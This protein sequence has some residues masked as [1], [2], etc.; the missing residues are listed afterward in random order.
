[1]LPSPVGVAENNSRMC[2]SIC[3]ALV[4]RQSSMAA[5][6]REVL[7]M[8]IAAAVIYRSTRKNKWRKLV[9]AWCSVNQQLDSP[10]RL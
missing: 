10:V 5:T 6:V 7:H 9:R 4:M 2:S 1:M 8:L 3:I